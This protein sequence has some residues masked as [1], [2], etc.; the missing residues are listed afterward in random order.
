MSLVIDIPGW[1]LLELEHLVLDLNGTLARDGRPLPG[2]EEAVARLA[3]SLRCHLLTA[4]TFGTAAGLFGPDLELARVSPGDQARQK[5]EFVRSLG[6]GSV[7]ALGN[8]A[9][10]VDMLYQ[11][12]LGI[13]VLGPEGACPEAL[14][15]AEVVV[16]GPREG[17]ELL[18]NPDRLRATLRR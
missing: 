16:P 12:A 17:L 10:D 5:L 7:V 9:N 3:R 4:D 14:A 6:A 15:A 11:A 13:A 1:R 18:L 2:V 8:G